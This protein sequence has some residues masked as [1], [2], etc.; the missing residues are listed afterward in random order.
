ME[1]HIRHGAPALGAVDP[2]GF[3]LDV[4][5]RRLRDLRISV[6][7]R[8]N[9]RCV[10]CMPRE[11]FGPDYQFL[12]RPEVLTFEE[13]R[14][15]AQVF[16]GLGV[17]KIRLTGG[18]PLLR[19]EVDKLVGMLREIDGL[20]D[21]TM[22]TNGSLLAGK[23]AAL[24]AAGLDRVTVSLDALDDALFRKMSDVQIPVDTVL[25]AIE[26][27]ADA[28][29]RPVKV[30]AVIKRGW[31]EGEILELADYFRGKGHVLRFIEFMDV[32]NSNGWRLEEVV[33]A[34]EIHDTI[35][36]RWP[37]EPLDANYVGEVASR[38]RYLDGAGE[39]GIISSVTQPFCADCNRA[40]LTADG[41][42]F[43]CLFARQGHNL[44][45]ALRGGASD[46]EM[47]DHVRSIWTGRVDRYSELR[48]L[49]TAGLPRVEMSRI[50]G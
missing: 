14:R 39:V 44:K 22:T 31:N 4:M 20:S 25:E 28:G 15:L 49:A 17:R 21:L 6:T 8:C 50:G 46:Q 47:A 7:D 41:E 18:E 1:D 43:T 30:N 19:R 2:A 42:F 9:F 29:L 45:T 34:R 26:V 13:I 24:A 23:A 11:V 33:P 48:S 40:R 16:V 12:P 5:G 27:A 35:N 37:I 3:P 36:D 10:Y 38:Y 32:G